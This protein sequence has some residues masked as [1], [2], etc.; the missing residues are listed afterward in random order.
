M[1][2]Y[3]HYQY[4]LVEDEIEDIGRCPKCGGELCITE[5]LPIQILQKHLVECVSCHE[6]INIYLGPL[7]DVILS[8]KMWLEC[9][10][11]E[12]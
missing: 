4:T 12:K 11:E 3:K 6:L 9:K 7:E 1:T 5:V 2:K 10:G 8:T